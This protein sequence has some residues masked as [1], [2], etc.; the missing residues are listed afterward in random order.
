MNEHGAKK[1]LAAPK[2][3][4]SKSKKAGLIFPSGRMARLMKQGRYADRFSATA[5]I[6]VAAVLEYLTAEVLEIAATAC[7]DNK[8][9][10]ITP[11]HLMLAIRNDEELSQLLGNVTI[12]DGGVL[13]YIHASLL[14][15][16][17]EVLDNVTIT[18]TVA[19]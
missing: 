11:R 3:K 12:S 19:P 17:K 10:R 2:A 6:Y 15:K 5:P 18:D 1:G 8:R 9:Q 16:R 13:P 14:P 7:T 4:I